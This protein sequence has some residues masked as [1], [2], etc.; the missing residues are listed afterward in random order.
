VPNSASNL[1]R[2][3]EWCYNNKAIAEYRE[4][5]TDDYVF[6]FNPT[7]SAGEAYRQVP[8]TREDEL[9]STAHLFVGGSADQP[10]ADRIQLTLDRSFTIVRD[11]NYKLSDPSGRWHKSIV[12]QI[13]FLIETTSDAQRVSGQVRFY[14]IR[15]D[16]ALIP[17]EIE[18]G[19]VRSRLQSL[20]HPPA[21]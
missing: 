21:G 4:L 20:V 1:L 6:F 10:P 5:F 7:D 11:D 13:D 19:R 17:D 12:T 3:F 15:G 9:I 2:L 8:W 18:A 16:S 14:V